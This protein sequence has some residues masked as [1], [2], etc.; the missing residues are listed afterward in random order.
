MPG[1]VNLHGNVK[2][3]RCFGVIVLL[4]YSRP[5]AFLECP[6][7][8]RF[9]EPGHPSDRAQL[10]S[11]SLLRRAPIA[12]HLRRAARSPGALRP[13]G[14]TRTG[15]RHSDPRSYS[16]SRLFTTS[17]AVW[18]P[19]RTARISPTICSRIQKSGLG[20]VTTTFLLPSAP[21]LPTSTSRGS[22]SR[23][24]APRGHGRS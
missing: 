5:P 17:T 13:G 14:V 1:A 9:G 6:M 18:S 7:D 24:A 21:Q 12:P 20:K 22:R 10:P 16:P 11:A 4:Q 3:A 2:I 15:L 19:T 23:A 8:R